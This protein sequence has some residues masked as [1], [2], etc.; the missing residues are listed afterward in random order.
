MT[1]KIIGKYKNKIRFL[2]LDCHYIENIKFKQFDDPVLMKE[3][4]QEKYNEL[5]A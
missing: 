3:L 1:S 2:C 5:P 4:L